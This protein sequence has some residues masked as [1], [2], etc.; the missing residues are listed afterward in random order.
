MHGC[1][2]QEGRETVCRKF[3]D[4]TQSWSYVDHILM[5]RGKLLDYL[6]LPNGGVVLMSRSPN[7]YLYDGKKINLVSQSFPYYDGSDLAVLDC[8]AVISNEEV[9]VGMAVRNGP[10]RFLYFINL[11]NGVSFLRT[12][13]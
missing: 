9:V 5:D 2:L 8:S 13:S 1:S 12:L 6:L 7:L 11:I 4:A 3:D 10:D